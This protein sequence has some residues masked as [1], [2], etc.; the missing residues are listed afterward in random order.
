[1]E[2]DIKVSVIMGAYN[3]EKTIERAVDSIMASTLKEIEMIVCDD[4]SSDCTFEVICELEKKYPKLKA[5]KNEANLTVAGALNHCLEYAK[6]DYIAVMDSD[7]QAYPDR[8]EKEAHFLDCHP[9]YAYVGAALDVDNGSMRFVRKYD[10]FPS[11]EKLLKGGYPYAHPTLMSRKEILNK[12]GNYDNSK[13]YYR[14]EDL[15]LGYRFLLA[16]YKGYNMQEPLVIYAESPKDF[17][18]R[19]KAN[20][21]RQF[22]LRQSVRILKEKPAWYDLYYMKSV[23]FA[24]L[25]E[26]ARYLIKKQTKK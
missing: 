14:C 22:R 25:P 16:G 20:A 24:F 2:K 11:L 23:I 8:L 3:R 6:G 26:R 1:M 17:I 21:I 19:S 12:I 5:I 13:D 9:E 7:D 18:R 15:E 4:G 10:E